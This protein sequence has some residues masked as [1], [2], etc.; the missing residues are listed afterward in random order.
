M[1]KQNI[2]IKLLASKIEQQKSFQK[3]L[4]TISLLFS[5]YFLFQHCELCKLRFLKLY[6]IRLIGLYICMG[7]QN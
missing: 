1:S 3:V 6:Y 7:I 2:F 4:L 5:K